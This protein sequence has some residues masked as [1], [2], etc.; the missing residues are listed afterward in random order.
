MILLKQWSE[1]H[2]AT[3]KEKNF[4]LLIRS[5]NRLVLRNEIAMYF[6]MTVTIFT[7]SCLILY[8]KKLTS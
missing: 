3:K 7:I 6:Y 2:P 1:I 4:S 8:S 5:D